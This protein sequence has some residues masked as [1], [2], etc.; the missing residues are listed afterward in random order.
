MRDD[1]E[2]PI[3]SESTGEIGIGFSI[4]V[5]FFGPVET[6]SAVFFTAVLLPAV[7]FTAAVVSATADLAAAIAAL[8]ERV[9]TLDSD[10][11]LIK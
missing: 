2:A 7:F 9:K 3:N 11:M 10:V 1:S 5:S 8:Y 4:P 6:F